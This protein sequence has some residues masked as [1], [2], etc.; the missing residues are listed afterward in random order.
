MAIS[1]ARRWY[2]R[3]LVDPSVSMTALGGEAGLDRSHVRRRLRLAMLAPDLVASIVSGRQD[4][5]LTIDG[6]T[7]APLPLDWREQRRLFAAS[8]A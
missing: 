8:K 4:G 6:L 1:N 7:K 2:R 5:S 3:L